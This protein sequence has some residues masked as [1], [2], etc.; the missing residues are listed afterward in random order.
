[1]SFCQDVKTELCDKNR[2]ELDERAE[3]YGILLF[4]RSFSLMDISLLT[5]N[6]AVSNAYRRAVRL[7]CGKEPK[8]SRTR[9]GKY[10]VS[11]DSA[12]D[13]R[14]VFSALDYESDLN[15]RILFTN[16]EPKPMADDDSRF[17]VYSAFVRGA[18][19]ASGIVT[20]PNR[21]YHIE[22]TCP[23]AAIRTDFIKLFDEFDTIEPKSTRR[24]SSYLIYIKNSSQI[25]DLLTLMGATDSTLRLIDT[26]VEREQ[27]N[28]SNRQINFTAAN[29]DKMITAAA[30]QTEAVET[31]ERYSSID[32]LPEELRRTA[33][34]RREF[35]TMSL[36]ELGKRLPE[37]ISKSGLS[38]RMKR[39]IEIA[40]ELSGH[41]I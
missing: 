22:F 32:M 26:K 11:V 6:E 19:L 28:N 24:G 37:R 14:A 13:R 40:E 4:G 39:I 21:A 25:E 23:T 29:I 33:E 10:C 17:G 34:L 15:K 31:I 7:L 27:A 30:R 5:E 9:A 36:S 12:E 16:F 41:D 8:V 2:D 38:H 1:M 3:A 18:F 20:D 35:P